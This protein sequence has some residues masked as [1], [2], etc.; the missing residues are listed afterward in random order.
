MTTSTLLFANDTAL[1][2]FFG[3]NGTTNVASLGGVTVQLSCTPALINLDIA[4]IME[5]VK[6]ALT[7]GAIVAIV[8]GSLIVVS[9]FPISFCAYRI[10]KKRRAN[11]INSAVPNTE[12]DDD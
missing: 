10:H 4:V 11:Q 7:P 8:I 12:R 2:G 1:L 3:S 5:Y 9:L 6:A